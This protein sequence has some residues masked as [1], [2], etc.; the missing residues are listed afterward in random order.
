MPVEP[1]SASAIFSAA[2]AAMA[3]GDEDLIG[4]YYSDETS[5]W[6]PLSGPIVGLDVV[7][8]LANIGRQWDRL[9]VELVNV[10][11]DDTSAA[12]EWVQRGSSSS[13]THVLR[14]SSFVTAR[15]G[16]LI[17]QRDY[18]DYRSSLRR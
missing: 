8:Y 15:D 12:L 13:G 14:G 2:M 6:D 1:A 3:S 18:F 9:T 10:S 5:Y 11:E 7:P 4:T 17:E 16:I